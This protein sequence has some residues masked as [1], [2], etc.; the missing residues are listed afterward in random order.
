VAQ[1]GSDSA[2]IVPEAVEAPPPAA[3][4]VARLK[5]IVPIGVEAVEQVGQAIESGA[6][7]RDAP[8]ARTKRLPPSAVPAT[9]EPAMAEKLG[10]AGVAE[11]VV[12]AIVVPAVVAE[13]DVTDFDCPVGGVFAFVEEQA[14]VTTASTTIGPRDTQ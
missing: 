8:S 14:A 6:L 13:V 11:V 4:S 1:A 5:S 9:Y 2:V 3:W 10:A 7:N 12:G